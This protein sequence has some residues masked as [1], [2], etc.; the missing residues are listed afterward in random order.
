ME[1]TEGDSTHPTK[2]TA[3][4]PINNE[5]SQEP[6]SSTATI[7]ANVKTT[8][9]PPQKSHLRT[10]KQEAQPQESTKA[11]ATTVKPQDT[12]IQYIIIAKNPTVFQKRQQSS[13]QIPIQTSKRIPA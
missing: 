9:K 3:V 8:A 2:I 4:T 13:I 11:T 7:V 1:N 5:R 6:T 12:T 10:L